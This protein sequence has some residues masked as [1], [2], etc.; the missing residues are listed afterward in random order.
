MLGTCRKKMTKKAYLLRG[1]LAFLLLGVWLSRSP[2]TVTRNP[3]PLTQGPELVSHFRT[4]TL[5]LL[6]HTLASREKIILPYWSISGFPALASVEDLVGWF[7]DHVWSL[8]SPEIWKVDWN[9]K[10]FQIQSHLPVLTNQGNDK[11]RLWLLLRNRH[12]QVLQAQVAWPEKSD[13]QGQRFVIPAAG[14]RAF[15]LQLKFTAS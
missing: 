7:A 15:L 1:G 11:A 6:R 8:E 14:A 2:Q 3:P 9:G 5:G 12:T 13:E 4:T 10:E